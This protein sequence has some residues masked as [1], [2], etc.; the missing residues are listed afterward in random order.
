MKKIKNTILYCVF[1]FVRTSVIQFYYGSGTVI[2]YG[3]SSDFLKSYSSGSIQQRVT[4]PDPVPVLQHCLMVLYSSFNTP[5]YAM[6]IYSMAW[7][8]EFAPL[9]PLWWKRIPM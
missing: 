2:N 4:V 9:D 5:I 8:T 7:T 3:S 6:T 1:V